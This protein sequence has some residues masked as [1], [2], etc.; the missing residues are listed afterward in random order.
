MLNPIN[1]KTTSTITILFLSK[2]FWGD[3]LCQNCG[4]Y[5][6]YHPYIIDGKYQSIA[7]Y[8]CDR[9]DVIALVGP[10]GV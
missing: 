9:C 6:T 5:I 2:E 4:D 10:N 8:W 1:P 3:D 7:G